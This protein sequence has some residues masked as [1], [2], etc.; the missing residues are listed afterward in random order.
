LDVWLAE[1]APIVGLTLVLSL[2][3]TGLA[4]LAGLPLGAMLARADFPGKRLLRRILETLMSLPPV[5]VGLL[6]FLLLSRRGPLGRLDLLFSLPAMILAQ[7]ILILPIVTSLTLAAVEHK[8]PD[9]RATLLGFDL[10]RGTMTRL[11]LRECRRTLP[12]VVLTGL[13]RALS[14]VGAVMMVGGNIQG[15]TRVLTTAIMLE[16][17][18]GRFSAALALGAVLLLL[19]FVINGL[20][21]LLREATVDA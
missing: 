3:S 16:T 10:P 19:S 8:L 17:S 20:L 21:G 7:F 11:L 4:S 15:K 6:V 1:L 5:V 13:G 12:A 2:C 9:I 18:R 14:E